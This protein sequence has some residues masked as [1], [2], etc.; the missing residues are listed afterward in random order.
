MAKILEYPFKLQG[1]KVYKRLGTIDLTY[2]GHYIQR[3]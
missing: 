1:D 2:L 3:Q